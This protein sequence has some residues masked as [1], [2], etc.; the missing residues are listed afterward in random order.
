RRLLYGR[1][2]ENDVRVLDWTVDGER[3]RAT[4]Q[5]RGQSVELD[6][7]MLGE[8]AVLNAAGALAVMFGLE[9]DVASAVAGMSEVAPTPGRLVPMLGTQDR[10]LIDDTYNSNPASV[11]VAVRTARAVAEQRGAPLVVVLG[12]MKE[13]GSHSEDEHRKVGDIVSE[14]GAFL[15]VGCGEEMHLGVD[16]ANA[17]GVDT[18]W[19]RTAAECAELDDRLP[20]NAVVLV[21]GSRS[22]EMERVLSP[23]RPED[24]A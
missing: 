16:V 24:G 7:R 15:F 18:L 17:R 5:V 3:T 22:M 13:L 12:D 23:M 8:G 4:V 19:F 14:S 9:L 20:L 2:A 21:K 11:E 1:A 10:F 6:L